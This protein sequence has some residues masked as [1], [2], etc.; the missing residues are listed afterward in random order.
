LFLF[1]TARATEATCTL[2]ALQISTFARR[3]IGAVRAVV[4][5]VATPD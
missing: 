5:H 3:S 1:Q 2:S 4:G